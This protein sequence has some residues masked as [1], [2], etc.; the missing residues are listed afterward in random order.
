MRGF[1][2]LDCLPI[3]H[4][5]NVCGLFCAKTH[6][7]VR[8]LVGDVG[9]IFIGVFGF[10]LLEIDLKHIRLIVLFN[11]PKWQRGKV[12]CFDVSKMVS[13]SAYL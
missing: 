9:G 8:V 11:S 6:R 1:E 10:L 3:S 12:D 7:Q 2:N 13:F 4:L 5:Q